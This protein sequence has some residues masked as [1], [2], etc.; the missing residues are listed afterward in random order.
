MVVLPSPGRGAN[1]TPAEQRIVPSPTLAGYVEPHYKQEFKYLLKDHNSLLRW[2]NRGGIGG[3]YG[4]ITGSLEEM[5]N[6]LGVA[7]EKG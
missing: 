5:R 2:V 6:Y 1:L 7:G 3:R 4:R